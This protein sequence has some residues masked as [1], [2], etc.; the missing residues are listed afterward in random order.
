M[1]EK[2]NRPDPPLQSCM[3]RDLG[4]NQT[5]YQR[6]G[7]R[8]G[9]RKGKRGKAGRREEKWKGRGKGIEREGQGKRRAGK[10]RQE[11]GKERGKG[12]A[13]ERGRLGKGESFQEE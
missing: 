3:M 10:D 1:N 6:K 11:R 2:G 4:G 8:E 13:R 7:K 9:E 5:T 12:K